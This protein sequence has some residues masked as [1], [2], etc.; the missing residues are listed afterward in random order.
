MPTIDA[1]A[2]RCEIDDAELIAYADGELPSARRTTLDAHVRGC[3]ACGE[4]LAAGRWIGQTLRTRLPLVD[5]PAGPMRVR[6]R[7][8]EVAGAETRRSWWRHPAAASVALPVLVLIAFFSLRF[9]S[10]NGSCPDCEPTAETGVERVSARYWVG[11]WPP[12]SA[13]DRATVGTRRGTGYQA[14]LGTSRS[15]SIGSLY[16]QGCAPAQRGWLD[17]Q[18]GASGAL[19]SRPAYPTRACAA[20]TPAG[21]WQAGQAGAYVP[22]LAAYGR[23]GAQVGRQPT[24]GFACG[25]QLRG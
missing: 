20:T 12:A 24:A 17:P 1:T 19:L 22:G 11:W 21:R 25:Q 5:D 14:S 10:E 7:L 6:A 23:N 3:A 13:C 18:P 16:G 2:L 4:R 8:A 15:S 9:L